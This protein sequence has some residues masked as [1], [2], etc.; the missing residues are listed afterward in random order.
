MII[1]TI[2]NIRELNNETSELYNLNYFNTKTL[3]DNEYTKENLK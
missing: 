3:N 2:V 1:K